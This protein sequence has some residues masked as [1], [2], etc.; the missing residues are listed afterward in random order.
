MEADSY[1]RGQEIVAVLWNQIFS[2]FARYYACFDPDNV[3]P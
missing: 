2:A 1:W 3:R